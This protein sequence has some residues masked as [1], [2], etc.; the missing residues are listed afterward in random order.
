MKTD[1]MTVIRDEFVDYVSQL[2]AMGGGDI[3]LAEFELYLRI[4]PPEKYF[5]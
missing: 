3:K 4:K 2:D 5:S 1:P